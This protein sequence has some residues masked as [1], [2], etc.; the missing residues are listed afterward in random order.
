MTTIHLE[1]LVEEQSMEAALLSL[2]PRL[3]PPDFSVEVRRFQGKMDL[4]KKLPERL[5]GYRN[6]DWKGWRLI[7]LVDRDADDCVKLKRRLDDMATE[8]GLL[9]RTA[10]DG[11]GWQIANRI[12]VEELEAW[13]FGDWAAV[14][15]AFPDVADNVPQRARFRDPDA[16]SGGTWEALERILQLHGYFKS[17]L[18]KIETARRIAE[19][20]SPTSNR[21]LSFRHFADAVRETGGSAPCEDT[22]S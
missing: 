5:R 19:H 14:K 12:V 17:G 6:W 16:I 11:G 13:F 20:M 21:S 22:S 15:A 1:F 3:L 2:A 18:P 4:L 9:T 7:V 10:A 8:A